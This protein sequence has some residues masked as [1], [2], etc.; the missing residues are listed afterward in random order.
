MW[1]EIVEVTYAGI[2]AGENGK[3]LGMSETPMVTNVHALE[4][5]EPTSALIPYLM[6]PITHKK[7]GSQDPYLSQ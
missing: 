7:K 4:L 6:F 3:V 5:W 1:Q 2:E